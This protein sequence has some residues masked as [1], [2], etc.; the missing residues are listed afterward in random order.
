[1][2]SLDLNVEDGVRIEKD[3]AVLLEE[4]GG[5]DLVV[6][7]D[8]CKGLCK[9]GI[10]CKRAEL[11]KLVCIGDPLGTDGFGDQLGQ[12]RV[13]GEQPAPGSDSVGL[14]LELLGVDL[15]EL[16]EHRVLEKIGMQLRH[17]VDCVAS[18]DCQ[19]G[20]ADVLG[21]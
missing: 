4:F 5:T 1:M 11:C 16:R 17:S 19:V 12:V 18:D 20:H 8:F 21:I 7:L 3:S 9:C 14:V 2:D 15:V 6:S 13:G 10:V